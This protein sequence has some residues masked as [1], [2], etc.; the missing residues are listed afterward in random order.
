[1]VDSPIQHSAINSLQVKSKEWVL[2]TLSYSCY[3]LT[4]C[5]YLDSTFKQRAV[6]H[7]DKAIQQA[8]SSQVSRY[9]TNHNPCLLSIDSNASVLYIGHLNLMI[10]CYRKLTRDTKYDKLNEVLSLSLYNRFCDSKF[11]CLESYPGHI[12]IPDNTVAIASLRLYEQYAN[13]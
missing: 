6:Q 5:A 9:F 1:M 7:I 4:N 11:M 12:W 8:M 10:G 2:F 13:S 3:A